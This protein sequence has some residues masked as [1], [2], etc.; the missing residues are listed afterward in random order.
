MSAACDLV[1]EFIQPTTGRR[2]PPTCCQQTHPGRQHARS[3]T[4]IR[5]PTA[6]TSCWP[7]TG[8]S[9]CLATLPASPPAFR[10]PE[11]AII[12]IKNRS[13]SI[14]AEVENPDGDAEGILVTLGGE[15][16]GFAFTGTLKKGESV[17]SGRT[18]PI[19]V[20]DSARKSPAP[21]PRLRVLIIRRTHEI[22]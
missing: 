18:P 19:E 17:N 5:W 6:L 16:G 1:F 4:S 21:P 8:P 20:L 11:E 15:T 22:E 13:F 12:D 9:S 3:T 7:L 2:Q 10:L 14:V